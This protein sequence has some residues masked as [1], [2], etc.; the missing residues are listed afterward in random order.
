V[1]CYAEL[2]D[3][4]PG[5][6]R[7]KEF[8]VPLSEAAS[9]GGL[10][11]GMGIRMAAVEVVL[12]NGV[13]CGLDRT[14]R[15]GDRV[16]LY[17]MFESFD[18][19]P[20]LHL[21]EEPLRRLRFVADA[22][23]G[24]LARYLRLLGFDTLFEN[25]PGDAELARIS[26]QEGRI[27]LSRDR[28]LLMRRILTHGLLIPVTRP[29]EQ[30]VY[31]VDRLD[32]CGLFKPFTRC[33]VCNGKL[34]S[35]DRETSRLQVPERVKSAFDAFWHCD[36]CGRFYWQGSHYERLRTLVEQLSQSRDR[37]RGGSG[38]LSG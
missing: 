8:L 3:Y 10:I 27:L 9:V 32:L 23:L 13:S 1:R 29:R 26:A 18:V 6:R 28:R 22:H 24:R 7:Q 35:V 20:L 11:D 30:L 38:L 37:H 14:L 31:L 16:S 12:V 25:D 2:N 15:D 21:R 34:A 19:A 17:P 36:G 33:T 5:G 4:L